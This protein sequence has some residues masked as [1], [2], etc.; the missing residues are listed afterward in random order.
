[1]YKYLFLLFSLIMFAQKYETQ[2][3]EVIN[4]LDDFEIR[5]YPPSN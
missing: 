4:K 1:M 5:Y 3:Y 2:K